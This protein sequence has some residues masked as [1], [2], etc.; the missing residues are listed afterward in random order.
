MNASLPTANPW[1][2]T[3]ALM[4][5]M[6]RRSWLALT[7]G[8]FG[9]L[10]VPVLILRALQAKGNLIAEDSAMILIHFTFTQIMGICFG[11]AVLHA[12]GTP[13]R[14][15]VLPLSNRAIMLLQMVPATLMV[16]GQ[17]M[18]SVWIL[19]QLFG[20]NWPLLGNALAFGMIFAS[21][22]ALVTLFQKSALL[23]PALCSALTLESFWVKSQHGPIFALPT[24]YWT[25]VTLMDWLVFGTALVLFYALGTHGIA[26]ARCGN[27][28]QT[29]LLEYLSTLISN[30]FG[31]KRVVF[32]NAIQAQSWYEWNLKGLVFPIIVA[33][34]VPTTGVIWLF[35][36]HNVAD[37][38]ETLRMEGWMLSAAAMIGGVILGNMGL[39]DASLAMSPF[40]GTKPLATVPWSRILLRAA[41][42]SLVL[43]VAI[44][45]GVYL[46][47]WWGR[48]LW[49]M[50]HG[51]E[52]F[53]WWD[54]PGRILAA[55]T[56]MTFAL[57]LSLTGRLIHLKILGGIYCGW[58]ASAM[59]VG[60]LSPDGVAEWYTLVSLSG[61]G[62]ALFLL[63]LWAWGLALRRRMVA[64]HQAILAS[65]V[66][67]AL[68][69]IAGWQMAYGTTLPGKP[70]IHHFLLISGVLSMAVFPFAAAPLALAWNRAR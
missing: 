19:N 27:E 16:V 22:Q 28:L 70:R 41:F 45:A 40:L 21:L 53:V 12:A 54:I 60:G 32:Q 10:S 49:G 3:R 46:L 2:I 17:T 20:L 36:D 26:R 4:T 24:H 44:W 63:T 33:M 11:A 52:P 51:L 13:A 30:L 57:C 35:T 55:W 64:G 14:L 31:R 23:L 62:I 61:C 37:L 1:S 29:K 15:F 69:G 66:V 34:V 18:A 38:L 6:F 42:R 9:A 7:L 68:V 25:T 65:L 43:G 39:S 5:D 56:A 47:V 67:V 59:L 48:E 8:F 50:N 58:L